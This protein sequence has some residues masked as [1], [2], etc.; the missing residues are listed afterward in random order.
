MILTV[1]K[2]GHPML[3]KKGSR[4][5]QITPGIRQL[6]ADMLETMQDAKGVGLAAQQVG[7]AVQLMAVDV[8][9]ILDRPSSLQMQG[10]SVDVRDFMPLVL[11]NPEIRPTADP[12]S[13]AE[14]CL[15][16]PEIYSDVSRP[17]AVE[18]TALNEKGEKL[19]F[20]CGGLL[21][22]AI[23][24]E[25]DHLNGILFIDRMTADGK[26]EIKPQIEDLQAETKAE[27]AVEA[28]AKR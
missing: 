19:E 4:I 11:I 8:R 27:L 13:G 12:V 5:E 14:G 1:L 18:V 25:Q 2:Y 23:Q 22:R 3:R 20:R 6:A 7:H 10:Q 21:A 15:S 28:K 24:H 17:A 26:K 16:F 9:D